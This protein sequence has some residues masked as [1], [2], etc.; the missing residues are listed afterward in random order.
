MASEAL[1]Q[2]EADAAWP[3]VLVS[4]SMLV[5]FLI[6]LTLSHSCFQ[7]LMVCPLALFLSL[8]L[9][10][11][12][13]TRLLISVLWAPISRK[14]IFRRTFR[15][16]NLLIRT[17]TSSVEANVLMGHVVTYSCDL[18]STGGCYYILNSIE[19]LMFIDIGPL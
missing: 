2:S 18:Y 12:K 16:N 13:D 14:S 7:A 11:L 6:S 4:K 10:L 5:S 19:N 15:N 8:L 17:I 3:V 9:I 1:C